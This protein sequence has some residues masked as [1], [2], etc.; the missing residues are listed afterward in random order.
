[1]SG[2]PSAVRRSWADRATQR[3]QNQL[4]HA[5]V[6]V[7]LDTSDDTL[8]ALKVEAEELAEYAATSSD[9]HAAAKFLGIRATVLQALH[10]MQ[11]DREAEGGGNESN[12][13]ETETKAL[14]F[15]RRRGW[16]CER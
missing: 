5:G 6:K 3:L 15:L 12:D 11:R 1:M 16:R 9:E 4:E 10:R 8:A 7:T 2:L 13:E 14:E